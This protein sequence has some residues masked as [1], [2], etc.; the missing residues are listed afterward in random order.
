M[1][2]IAC[3]IAFTT[4]IPANAVSTQRHRQLQFTN[5]TPIVITTQPI[6]LRTSSSVLV[7]CEPAVFEIHGAKPAQYSS[8]IWTRY[9]SGNSQITLA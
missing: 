1:L 5:T 3:N 9:V 2:A 8:A 7:R 6:P 4:T